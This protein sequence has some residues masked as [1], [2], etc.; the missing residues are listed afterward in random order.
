MKKLKMNSAYLA[1]CCHYH[2][3]ELSKCLCVPAALVCV[4]THVMCV[5]LCVCVDNVGSHYS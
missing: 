3:D 4:Y 5:C 2:G 1:L